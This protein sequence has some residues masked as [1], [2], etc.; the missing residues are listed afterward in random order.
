[1]TV[2][3]ISNIALA[4]VVIA[5]LLLSFFT[6]FSSLPGRH[7]YYCSVLVCYNLVVV[8]VVVVVNL[9]SMKFLP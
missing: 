4:V 8:V 5:I 9:D 1:M 2:M 3:K 6:S 7:E